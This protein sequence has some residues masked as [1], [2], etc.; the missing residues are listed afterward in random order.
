MPPPNFFY[1]KHISLIP[2][3]QI[4]H[5]LNLIS[6]LYRRKS[7]SVHP[8]ELLQFRFAVSCLRPPASS[9]LHRQAFDCFD[10]APTHADHRQGKSDFD[11]ILWFLD[12]INLISFR[13]VMKLISILRLPNQFPSQRLSAIPICCVI[14]P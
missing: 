3:H 7:E 4:I 1:R 6:F 2:C 9:A 13:S 8:S 10:F 14:L 5:S 11:L 12:E